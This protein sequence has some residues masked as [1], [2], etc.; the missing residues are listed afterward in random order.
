MPPDS[1]VLTPHSRNQLCRTLADQRLRD[2]LAERR[3]FLWMPG[4][5]GGE[6]LPSIAAQNNSIE[7]KD[8]PF[9]PPP[10]A[11]RGQAAAAE[12]RQERTLRNDRLMRRLMIQRCDK[13][14][15]RKSV[16]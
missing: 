4:C 3:R 9:H 5:R 13:V 16:V 10:P 12:G 6:P 1:Y 11:D 2:L 14:S 8:F 7:E 15:D